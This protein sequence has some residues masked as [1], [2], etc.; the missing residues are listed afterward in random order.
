M[1][2]DTAILQH[3]V[4]GQIKEAPIGFS[5]TMFFFNWI[6]PIF[7]GDWKWFGIVLGLS[8]FFGLISFGLLAWVPG[9]VGSFVW[10]KSHLNGL[11]ER[12]YQV[13]AMASG[14]G[15]DRADSFAGFQ[16]PRYA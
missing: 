15:P 1:A 11:V 2:Y 14:A 10:N 6:P 9:L 4:T 8:I 12:G 16:L 3:P 7:R 5:W 13:K